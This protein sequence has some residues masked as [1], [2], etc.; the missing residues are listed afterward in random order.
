MPGGQIGGLA[1]GTTNCTKCGLVEIYGGEEAG[2]FNSFIFYENILEL[3]SKL[4]KALYTD[5][6]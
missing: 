3:K 2:E 6:I 5:I 1:K 4:L